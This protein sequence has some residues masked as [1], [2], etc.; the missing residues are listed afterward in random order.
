[1]V[2]H[3]ALFIH[4][5]DVAAGKAG[6]LNIL[7]HPVI[8]L[9]VHYPKAVDVFAVGNGNVVHVVLNR[10]LHKLFGS[11]SRNNNGRQHNDKSC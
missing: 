5:I 7:K 9:V 3:C 10:I 4:H 8:M 6:D 2:K 11:V 1:M